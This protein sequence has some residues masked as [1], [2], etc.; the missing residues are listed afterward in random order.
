MRMFL[1][2][3]AGLMLAPA[4]AIAC[5]YPGGLRATNSALL[6][7]LDAGG[8]V[9]VHHRQ[10]L[11]RHLDQINPAAVMQSLDQDVSRRDARAAGAVLATAQALADGR[12]LQ[13]DGALRDDLRRVSDAVDA[14]CSG[15]TDVAVGPEQADGAEHGTDR[16]EG[17]G[18]RGL[19][20][21]EGVAR[22]SLTFTLYLAFLAFLLGLRRQWR[23]RSRAAP[24]TGTIPQLER[25]RT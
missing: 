9:S 19:T 1:A 18:G 15:G 14:A 21:R 20:F 25:K 4:V 16:S 2:V 22:L 23:E 10:T 24:A 12:G 7:I 13:V 6:A 11:R 17:Q 5:A 3:L 8:T